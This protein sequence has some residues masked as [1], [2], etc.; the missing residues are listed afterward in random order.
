MSQEIQLQSPTQDDAAAYA[1]KRTTFSAIIWSGSLVP[2][3]VYASFIS[4]FFLIHGFSIQRGQ[5]EGVGARKKHYEQVAVLI[6][7]LCILV[8]F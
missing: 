7:N 3:K 6:S 1:N 8:S 2:W 4:V 5:K